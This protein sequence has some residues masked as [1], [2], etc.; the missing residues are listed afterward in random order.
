MVTPGAGI[1]ESASCSE[2]ATTLS[3]TALKL[4]RPLAPRRVRVGR[5]KAPGPR[6]DGSCAA[7]AGGYID[8]STPAWELYSESEGI[9]SDSISPL[10]LASWPASLSHGCVSWAGPELGSTAS[11]RVRAR[12]APG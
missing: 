3:A 2:M 8:G 5:Q 9:V 7:Y 4:A 1:F 10:A 6:P 11:F 12:G